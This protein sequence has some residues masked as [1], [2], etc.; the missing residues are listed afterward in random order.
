MLRD[1]IAF[2]KSKFNPFYHYCLEL[3]TTAIPTTTP[4][5]PPPTTNTTVA[6][7]TTTA[8]KYLSLDDYLAK[9]NTAEK[10]NGLHKK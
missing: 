6:K 9:Y 10:G 7:S 1:L 5:I 4:R 2:T 3:A 8:G